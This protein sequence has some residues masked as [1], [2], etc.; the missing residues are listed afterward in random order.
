M[1][2]CYIRFIVLHYDAI[3]FLYLNDIDQKTGGIIC[4]N[5]LERVRNSLIFEKNSDII[6]AWYQ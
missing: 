4:S 6:T 3:L 2:F 5:N 1:R